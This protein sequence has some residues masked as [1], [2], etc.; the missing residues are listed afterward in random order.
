MPPPPPGPSQ[1]RRHPDFAKD[2]QYP[3][4]NQQ[5]PTYPGESSFTFKNVFFRGSLIAEMR[6]VTRLYIIYI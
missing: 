1:P 6:I 2:Q 5:R 3:Q 4:Y